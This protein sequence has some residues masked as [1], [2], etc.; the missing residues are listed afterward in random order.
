[1]L[2][3]VGCVLFG[4]GVGNLVSLPPLIAQR[5]FRPADV[6][7]VVALVTAT[8]QAVFAFAPAIYGGLRDFTGGYLVA[9]LTGAA[10]QVVA[11]ITVT[12]RSRFF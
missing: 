8:N 7:T 4:L 5:E 1:M 11:A 9:F 2:L 6:G 12:S 10:I 3:A